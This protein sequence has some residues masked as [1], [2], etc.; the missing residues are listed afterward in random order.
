LEEATCQ[1]HF[2]FFFTARGPSAPVVGKVLN[3]NDLSV[4]RLNRG[5]ASVPESGE[6]IKNR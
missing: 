4:H 3:Q 5:V 6:F 2:L 1:A